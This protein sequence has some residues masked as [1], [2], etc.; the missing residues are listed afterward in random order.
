MKNY[1]CA[2]II[3]HFTI[4]HYVVYDARN[5]GTTQMRNPAQSLAGTRARRSFNDN[6]NANDDELHLGLNEND[7]QDDDEDDFMQEKVMG[8]RRAERG[9]LPWA[10]LL[11]ISYNGD[12]Y[13]CGGT[14]VSRRHVITAAHCFW[15]SNNKKMGCCSPWDMLPEIDAIHN[16]EVFIGG[17]CS[18]AGRFGCTWSDIGRKYKIAR[19][20]SAEITAANAFYVLYFAYG[21]NGTYDIAILELTEDVP[22]TINH[23][24]LPFMH[25]LEELEDPYLELRSFGWGADPL[26]H[27][28][29]PPPTSPYLQIADLGAKLSKETCDRMKPFEAEDTFCTRSNGQIVCQ[30]DSGGGLTTK[31]R[32]RS[33]LVGIVSYGPKCNSIAEMLP[34]QSLQ[35]YTD[36]MYHKK[37][38]ETRIQTSS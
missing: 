29:E 18:S 13:V 8:G 27:A 16:T 15:A 17:T 4:G 30:G 10:V 12:T 1:V 3:F 11:K 9:E 32:G 38:I 14:L 19:Y 26:N 35:V 20:V 33:Y 24:C 28:G 36:I 37:M 21:C 22:K 2:L 7:V 23:I 5:C 6:S 34:R 31:I 25:H